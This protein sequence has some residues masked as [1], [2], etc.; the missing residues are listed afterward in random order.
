MI[1]LARFLTRDQK[2]KDRRLQRSLRREDSQRAVKITQCHDSWELSITF[3]DSFP[4]SCS[5]FLQRRSSC[6]LLVAWIVSSIVAWIVPVNQMD[7]MPRVV[8]V[9]NILLCANKW[10]VVVFYDERSETTEKLDWDRR[11]CTVSSLGTCI[12]PDTILLHSYCNFSSKQIPSSAG[13]YEDSISPF[14]LTVLLHSSFFWIMMMKKGSQEESFSGESRVKRIDS[15]IREHPRILTTTTTR[16]TSFPET[17]CTQP[18]IFELREQVRWSE[19]G[20]TRN[21]IIL[22][23]TFHSETCKPLWKVCLRV[24]KRLLLQRLTWDLWRLSSI[25]IY[26]SSRANFSVVR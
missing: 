17:T 25:D 3:S 5:F 2:L 15:F 16:Q 13:K 8:D 7:M 23:W 21:E 19:G 9:L 6:T 4:F 22:R 12:T 14:C 26:S 11:G 24:M 20:W 10:S 1:F 18:E